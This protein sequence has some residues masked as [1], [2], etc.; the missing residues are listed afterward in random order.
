MDSSRKTVE[1]KTGLKPEQAERLDF[2][3]KKYKFR[4]RYQLLQFLVISFLKVADPKPDEVVNEDLRLM[5]GDATYWGEQDNTKRKSNISSKEVDLSKDICPVMKKY[6]DR[7]INENYTRL[8]AKF[9][10]IDNYINEKSISSLDKLNTTMRNLYYTP[11]E[12][13]DYKSFEKWANNK[14][15]A[16]KDR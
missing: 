7:Y 14:F 11:I 15:T 9:R 2:I 3:I 13:Q 12:F 6:V 8:E 1:M 4:S 5:F 16:K 10:N